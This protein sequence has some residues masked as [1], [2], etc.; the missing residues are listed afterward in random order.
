MKQTQRFSIILLSIVGLLSLGTDRLL[1]YAQGVGQDSVLF[2]TSFESETD[3]SGWQGVSTSQFRTDAPLN[4]GAQSLFISG[5][6]VIPHASYAISA[7][8]NDSYLILRCWGKNLG[9]GGS[10]TLGLASQW[11][12]GLHITIEDSVW[13]E[14]TSSDTLFCPKGEGLLLALF[15]GGIVPSAMEVDLIE[16][17]VVRIVV[18][19]ENDVPTAGHFELLQNYPNPFNP[20]T[21]IEFFLPRSEVVTLKIFNVLGNE[22]TTLASERM[23]SGLHAQRWEATGYPSGV[24]FCRLQAGDLI[25]TKRMLLLR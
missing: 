20:Q 14:Y 1:S 9:I 25:Q 2:F 12:E 5:G 11:P 24:Y 3:T 23:A 18:E 7:L 21:T 8:E 15:A 10:V 17:H 19:V 6:C 16:I 22:V 13:T 4:G